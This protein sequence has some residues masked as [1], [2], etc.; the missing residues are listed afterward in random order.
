MLDS[1]VDGNRMSA[2][3]VHDRVTLEAVRSV[4]EVPA[5]EVSG[6]VAEVSADLDMYFGDPS[7][8]GTTPLDGVPQAAPR[9]ARSAWARATPT[10][11]PLRS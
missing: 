6:V 11:L 3:A 10:A 8:D 4:Q 1:P 9:S 7:P 5:V 2:I